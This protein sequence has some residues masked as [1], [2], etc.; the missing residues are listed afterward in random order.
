[1]CGR[2]LESHTSALWLCCTI[3]S[4]I[5]RRRRARSGVTRLR[6]SQ[7][8]GCLAYRQS[9]PLGKPRSSSNIL[10]LGSLYHCR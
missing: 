8:P 2:A 10:D 4:R 6:D 7:G 5:R 3:V 1:M 9:H